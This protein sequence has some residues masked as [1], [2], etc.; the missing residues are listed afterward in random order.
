M[1]NDQKLDMSAFEYSTEMHDDMGQLPDGGDTYSLPELQTAIENIV[2]TMQQFVADV[3]TVINQAGA[4]IE[5]LE[6]QNRH[7]FQLVHIVAQRTDWM[8]EDRKDLLTKEVAYL[9][10]L[11]AKATK[12]GLNEKQEQVP[13]MPS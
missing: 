12:D 7:L 13:G 8:M 1:S 5:A 11:K 3:N 4:R 10:E 6:T 9:K 2:S